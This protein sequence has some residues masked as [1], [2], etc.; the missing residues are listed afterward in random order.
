[1][2]GGNGNC[3]NIPHGPHFLCIWLGDI[4]PDL[5]HTLTFYILLCIFF[6]VFYA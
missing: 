3:D 2:F 6:S 1:M 4:A 5:H